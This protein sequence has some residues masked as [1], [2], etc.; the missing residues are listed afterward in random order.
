[1]TPSTAGQMPGTEHTLERDRLA[2]A[3]PAPAAQKADASTAPWRVLV[4]E[5]V[6]SLQ[7]LLAMVLR[8]AG[9]LVMSAD[10]GRQAVE[11]ASREP[12]DLV[13]MD[14]QMPDMNGLD[15]TRAIRAREARTGAHLPIVA[16]TA[17]ALPGDAQTC[18]DAGADA[19]LRKPVDLAALLPF[20][21]R[22]IQD[23]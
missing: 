8:K 17:Y 14:I 3:Q 20:L 21:Q 12:F 5:D 23:A 1:M 2:D 18:L 13:L 16:I 6:P 22:L 11:L 9:H 15:A 7:K 19:Y 4:V 10:N